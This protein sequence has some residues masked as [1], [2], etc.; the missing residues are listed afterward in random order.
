MPGFNYITAKKGKLSCLWRGLL[1]LLLLCCSGY[2][3]LSQVISNKGA[4][5]KIHNDVFVISKDAINTTGSIINNGNLNLFGNYT[6]TANTLGNG[7][8][9]LGGNWTNTGGIFTPGSSTVIF[10]GTS[11]QLISKTGGEIFNNFSLVNTGADPSN[12]VIL[13]DNVEVGGTLT[14]TSGNI[15]TGSSVMYLSDFNALSL[16]YIST[17]GSRV[18][19]KFRRGVGE[20]GKDFLFPIGNA[21]HYNPLNLKNNSSFF[22]AGNILS[23]FITADPGNIGLPLEDP[24]VEVDTTFKDGYWNLVADGFSSGDYNI[25]LNGTGFSDTVTS[26]TRIL[27]RDTGGDWEI[28][29]SHEVAD[30]VKSVAYRKNLGEDISPSG[31]QYALGR[32]RPLIVKQPKDTIVCEDTNP[33][34]K[35]ISTGA[36]TLKFQWYKV[37]EPKDLKLSNGS[38]YRGVRTDS[39]TI[40]NAQLS[41]TGRYYCIITDRY[42]KSN[43]TDTVTLRVNKIPVATATPTAQDEE[44]TN[45]SIDQIFMGETYG[46]DDAIFLWTRDNPA[47]ITSAMPLDGVVLAEGLAIPSYSFENITDSPIT[48]TFTIIPQGPNPTLCTGIPITA[49][50]TVNPKPRVVAL[51]MKPEICD[52]GT[53]E[54][55]LTS[56]TAM[57]SGNIKFD[58]N[59]TKTGGAELIGNTDPASDLS[60]G[61]KLEFQYENNSASIQSVHY[62]VTPKVDNYVC[63]PGDVVDV[64]V[65]VH[66]VPVLGITELEPMKCDG[67]VTSGALRVDIPAGAD[68]YSVEWFG[69]TNYHN[70]TDFS[71]F[72]VSEGRYDVIVTDN[73]GCVGSD[74]IS[75]NASIPRPYLYAK[76]ITCRDSADARLYIGVNS[77]I[78]PFTYE[79]FKNNVLIDNGNFIDTYPAEMKQY[80]NI[81]AG[82]FKLM[83]TDKNGCTGSISVNLQDP[84]LMKA[85]FDV[86]KV[87]CK[88]GTNGS[89]KVTMTGGR[90]G[91]YTYH[92]T[93]TDGLITG[94]DNTNE[95]I[96]VSA[97]TYYVDV[98]DKL[99]CPSRFT[100]IVGEPDGMELV[101]FAA[102]NITCNGL[103]DGSISMKI[104]GGTGAYSYSWT[105]PNGFT[106]IAD[107]I[108]GLFPGTYTCTVTDEQGCM[109]YA[110][111]GVKPSFTLTQPEAISVIGVL[112]SSL[113]GGYNINCNDG[114]GSVN[115]D[116]TGGTGNYSY[117]WS[118]SD[119]SGIIAGE[120]D[121]PSLKA[122][123]YKLIVRDGNKCPATIDYVI[124]EPDPLTIKL[125]PVDITCD[126]DQSF[127]NGSIDL[128]VTGG[129]SGYSYTWSNGAATENISGLNEGTYTVTVT[130]LNNCTASGSATIKLPPPLK[131]ST[132]LSQYKSYEVSCYGLADGEIYVTAE[133]G[134]GPFTYSLKGPD[135]YF[136][137]N[138][139]GKFLS[140]KAGEY[141]LVVTDANHC[142]AQ[143]VI[144]L[145]EP[146]KLEARFVLSNSVF[147]GYNINCAGDSTGTIVVNPH[148]S[149]NNVAY[150]W[151][152]GF[153][154][155]SRSGLKA[156]EYHVVITDDNYCQAEATAV[157]TQPDSIKLSLVITPPFCPAM[158]DGAISTI[159]SRGIPGMQ[160]SYKWSD[161][162]S[163]EHLINIP[164]GYYKVNIT[165][166]NGCVVRDSVNLVPENETCLIIPN[167][168]SPNGD[169]VNDYWNIGKK[170]LYPDMVITIFNRWGD[171]V[172]KSERGYPNPWNGRGNGIA[173][174][175]DSYHY[176]IDLKDGSEPLIGN[177]TIVK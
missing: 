79:L 89:V 78:S 61:T 41:D 14:M 176:I 4:F 64:E 161:N 154:G 19:G 30:T 119:G 160:Y 135:N 48:V 37:A 38:E 22:V 171:P 34:F 63:P 62:Y 129:V 52:L 174:P 157:L 75:F 128:I 164:G 108:S 87:S 137:V 105:G 46:V 109:L 136:V 112:S 69:P 27:K 31:T 141:E 144:R 7:F 177:I 50:I 133:S 59:I 138:A 39:L 10:N 16:N 57:T 155:R 107:T 26:V 81:S 83:I 43:R 113:N 132:I 153:S 23:E 159:I 149:V 13:N 1:L 147:G 98:N 99:G 168:I 140:L 15:L 175:V 163:T 134:Q 148:N 29:G 85:T 42:K 145:R 17:S 71:L 158:P 21:N 116:V 165:D 35:V 117:E 170:E 162:S 123:T 101:S 94:A 18:I 106:S 65:K 51:N 139:T 91:P 156:G 72:D 92:W 146:G 151:S 67:S 66:A 124:T 88:G 80:D 152:D 115:I 126:A 2:D 86:T 44:C 3:G 12:R 47:G 20:T 36:R 70:T 58:Y 54:I 95:L 122:G 118:T 100:V 120:K 73:L 90:G 9:R 28:D 56:P 82:I 76:A 8:Y 150:I 45:I 93:T 74:S 5:I 97:G 114:T 166:L 77:G 103:S 111:P 142:T 60:R 96:D 173:L 6:S 32:A 84:P 68:P 143:E 130:D 11:L 125:Y 121:Q 110:T 102:R 172:W 167:I 55:T 104:K 25:N 49:T 53:T 131:I 169:L 40:L 33:F 127:D 24:P